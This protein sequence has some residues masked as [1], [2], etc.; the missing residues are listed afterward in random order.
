VWI[1][2][3]KN[4]SALEEG[5]SAKALSIASQRADVDFRENAGL[6]NPNLRDRIHELTELHFE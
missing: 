6:K 3:K 1:E 4:P 2:S 5:I